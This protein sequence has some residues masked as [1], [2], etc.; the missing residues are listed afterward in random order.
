MAFQSREKMKILYVNP[1]SYISGSGMSLLALVKDLDKSKFR[2]YVALPESGPLEKELSRYTNNIY[3]IRMVKLKRGVIAA[4]DLLLSF[5]PSII[6]LYSLIKRESIDIVHVNSLMSPYGGIA[7][8]LAGVRC[9]Y[10]IREN[11]E[12]YPLVVFRLLSYLVLWMADRIIVVAKSVGEPFERNRDKVVVVYNGV[13][14]NAF[15]PGISSQDLYRELEIEKDAKVIITVAGIG[16][17]KGQ[18]YLIEALPTVLAKF[19]D[20]KVL[21][22]GA[23]GDSKGG[24]RYYNHLQNRIHELGLQGHVLFL[25]ARTDV[26]ELVSLADVFVLPSLTEAFPRVTLEAMALAKPVIATDVGGCSEQIDQGVTGY[27]VPPRNSDALADAVI[28]VLA[29]ENR[30]KNMGIKA[31]EKLVSSFASLRTT[32]SIEKIYAALQQ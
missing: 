7:A 12:T 15:T 31:R 29:D 32:E 22:V 27:L 11:K 2:P 14:I 18:M 17:R 5:I 23:I 9:I 4:L 19:A 6:R 16:E 21:F 28:E 3:I 26:A 20:C 10:H 1:N 13:D 30:G 25:G 8:K 24:K